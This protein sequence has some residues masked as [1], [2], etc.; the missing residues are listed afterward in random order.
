VYGAPAGGTGND[1]V[2]GKGGAPT[3]GAASGGSGAPGTVYGAPTAGFSGIP[4]YGAAPAD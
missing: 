3:A 2:G 1:D 4:L